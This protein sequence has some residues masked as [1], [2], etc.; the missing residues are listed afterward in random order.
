MGFHPGP[1]H[2]RQLAETVGPNITSVEYV[3]AL[4][5]ALHGVPDDHPSAYRIAA[6]LLAA[7]TPAPVVRVFSGIARRHPREPRVHRM[8]G[9]AHL[10]AG[11]VSVAVR[12]FELT[13]RLLR[14]RVTADLSMDDSLR[15][16]L[17]AATLRLVL[18]PLYALLGRREAAL[19]LA[20]ESFS[21]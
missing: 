21:L 18:L 8:L 5:R 11:D 6:R 3:V 14:R 13:L 2:L 9:L 16:R 7:G 12:H 10:Q 20:A 15:A 4:S 19:R 17:D 1:D